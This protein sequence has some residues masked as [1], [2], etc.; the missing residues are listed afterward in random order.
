MNPEKIKFYLQN[1]L[2]SVVTPKVN[3]KRGEA[4]FSKA[5]FDVYQIVKGSFQ[6]PI[7][8]IFLDTEPL[9]QKKSGLKPHVIMMM[10]G[11]QKDI[12]NFFKVL[13]INSPTKVHW[14]KRPIFKNDSLHT[15][16]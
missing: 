6:P 11:V 2:D 8:H 10:D 16:D 15:T 13:S 5:K 9:I 3:K 4:G 1:Y 7:Y 12:N 14:N